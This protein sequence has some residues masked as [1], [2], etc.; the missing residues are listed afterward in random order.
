MKSV[1]FEDQNKIYAKDQPEYNKLIVHKKIDGQVISCWELSDEDIEQIL[2][3]RQVYLT[4]LT[5]RMALQPVS[6][7][8]FNPC[9]NYQPIKQSREYILMTQDDNS[10]AAGIACLVCAPSAEDVIQVQNVEKE[11]NIE[12]AMQALDSFLKNHGFKRNRYLVEPKGLRIPYLVV[13]KV[14]KTRHMNSIVRFQ[15]QDLHNTNAKDIPIE[16]VLFYETF[17]PI[18][19]PDDAS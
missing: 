17:T 19:E 16:Q 5:F 15:G 8:P 6:L 10:Y 3:T 7:S 2:Q 18:N 13:G 12:K 14:D 1:N 11:R 9:Y 4:Q